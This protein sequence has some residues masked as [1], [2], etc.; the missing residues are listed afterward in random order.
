MRGTRAPWVDIAAVG[1]KVEEW[2]REARTARQDAMKQ[3]ETRQL[4]HEE[5]MRLFDE[6]RLL[7]QRVKRAHLEVLRKALDYLAL[8]YAQRSVPY[9]RRLT[10]QRIAWHGRIESQGANFQDAAP[11]GEL[12]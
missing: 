1:E 10:I 11:L 8:F 5:T 3:R 9:D 7:E 12:A 6:V 2:E 4:S